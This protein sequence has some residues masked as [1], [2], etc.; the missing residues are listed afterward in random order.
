MTEVT[1][2]SASDWDEVYRT[3]VAAGRTF[4][5][6]KPEG[7]FFPA[8][9][10]SAPSLPLENTFVLYEGE[11]LVSALQAYERR[12]IVGGVSVPIAALGNVFTVPERQ[13]CGHGSRL[14]EYARQRLSERG[15]AASILLTET[16][17]FY[18]QH[19]WREL[20]YTIRACPDPACVRRQ[21]DGRWITF[22][23]DSHLATL[24]TI[25]R[26]T[27]Q[28]E[29]GRLLRPEALWRQW[30]F[31]TETEVISPEQVHL[32]YPRET[33][34]GY[35]IFSDDDQVTCHEIGYV[36]GDTERFLF[37]A[38]NFLCRS[39]ADV[40]EWVPPQIDRITDELTRAGC[41]FSERNA[42]RCLLQVHRDD[43]LSSICGDQVTSTRDF[44]Q[45]LTTDGDWYWSPVDSI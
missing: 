4:S 41:T 10:V 12:M 16:P 39:T 8:R 34:E 21:S 28:S 33:V 2:R 6:R 37:E 36:G 42:S 31:G 45:Y 23:F 25:Y 29:R 19:G 5:G 22:D 17:S 32:Y 43:L 44:R 38:W 1:I 11:T 35:L 15:Y 3:A 9:T 30:I 24:R 18:E 20:P 13:G 26:Q 40:L 7:A 27:R 14:L